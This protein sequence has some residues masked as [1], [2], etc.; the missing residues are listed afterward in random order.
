MTYQAEFEDNEMVVFDAG[1][2]VDAMEQAWKFESEHGSLFN[3]FLLDDDFN[4][5]RTVF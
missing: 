4:E 5:I 3:V 2:D 1:N